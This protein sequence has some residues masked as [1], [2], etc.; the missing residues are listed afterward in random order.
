MNMSC[1]EGKLCNILNRGRRQGRDVPPLLQRRFSS[2][3]RIVS[4]LTVCLRV[5]ILTLHICWLNEISRKLCNANMFSL[6]NLQKRILERIRKERDA[7]KFKESLLNN[8]VKS[9]PGEVVKFEQTNHFS[10]NG[11]YYKNEPV[12]S[13]NSSSRSTDNTLGNSL[14]SS[15]D[16]K[17]R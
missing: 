10:G 9:P 1:I 14:H 3:L 11:A 7:I 12:I 6:L 5:H 13:F 17:Y 15:P 2:Y 16:G 8:N 4:M